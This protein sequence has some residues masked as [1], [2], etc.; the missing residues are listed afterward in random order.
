[1]SPVLDEIST[2]WKAGIGAAAVLGGVA[3]Y[4]GFISW[5][6]YAWGAFYVSL[7]VLIY[8]LWVLFSTWACSWPWPFSIVSG[9][10][11]DAPDNPSGGRR[12]QMHSSALD[13]F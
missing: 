1:M 3:A 12:T 5:S 13:D 4:T 8:Y 7:A 10:F 9:L 11:C 6:A 2:P